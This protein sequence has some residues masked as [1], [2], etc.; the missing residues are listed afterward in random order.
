M[1]Y[2]PYES[3]FAFVFFLQESEAGIEG[4]EWISAVLKGLKRSSPTGLKITL[5]SVTNFDAFFVATYKSLA[6]DLERMFSI[7]FE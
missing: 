3:Y 2:D 6:T 7:Q 1:L 4:N 5:R